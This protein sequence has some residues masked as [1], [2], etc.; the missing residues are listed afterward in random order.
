MGRE[1]LFGVIGGLGLFIFGMRFLSDG[2]QRV[3]STR[4]RQIITMFT[5]KPL[6]GIIS[7]CMLTALIQSSSATTV[8]TIGFVNSGIM[9]LRQ[10]IGVI[11]GANIGT[12]ITAQII[13]F[14]ISAYSLPAIG[15]GA[16]FFIFGRT[17]KL[18]FWGQVILGFGILFLGLTTMGSV[19]KELK[20]S[21]MAT[22]FFVK[23]GHNPFMGVMIGTLVTVVIQSSSASIGLVIA[24]ASNGL[25]DFEAAIYL[26]LGDNIGTTITAWLASLG[27]N[28]T[29]RR[30]AMAHSVFN[31]VGATYFAY[32]TS[33]GLFINL[34]DYLTPGGITTDTIARNIAN[35]HTLFN[36]INAVIFFPL[37][38]LMEKIVKMLLPGSESVSTVPC[39][40]EKNLLDT[41]EIAISQAKK[42]MLRMLSIS[43][44]AV[45]D[46]TESFL[47]KDRRLLKSVPK[48]EDAIDNLQGEITTYLVEIS[49]NTLTNEQS[50]QLPTLLHSVN[51]IEKIGDH[52]EN[53]MKLAER[54][55]DQKLEFH[56]K[57]IKEVE[58]MYTNITDMF[59]LL[60]HALAKEEF[61]DVRKAFKMEANINTTYKIM[62]KEQLRHLQ[63]GRSYVI[64]GIV[65][66]DLINN[67]EKVADHL[68]NIAEAITIQFRYQYSK[69]RQH[70]HGD[71]REKRDA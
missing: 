8:M 49:K 16:G 59:D 37:I 70:S 6:L 1:L 65:I 2:L 38:P 60:L 69:P 53:I 44:D 21:P 67:L 62:G 7:G 55:I 12:T 52:A 10:A 14:K 63:R 36:I 11:I 57:G 32:F 20:N 5:D 43:K 64:S 28:L 50:E 56:P 48:M 19:L 4:L 17:K 66:L 26:V 51:D 18:Q 40:L 25:I 15:I 31:L 30:V 45:V 46:S 33:N 71:L 39:Y 24:L 54:V 27:T 29:S 41:P 35:A 23:L 47:K 13:A 68:T 22:E 61:T 34:V 3:A 9:L 42:E 58:S